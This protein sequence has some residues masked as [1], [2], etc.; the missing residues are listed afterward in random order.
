MKLTVRV[1]YLHY[2]LNRFF[3]GEQ[4][5]SGFVLGCNPIDMLLQSTLECLYD[6]TCF[7]LIN[8]GNLSSIYP[9]NASVPSRYR[10]NSTAE[11]LGM[12]TFLEEVIQLV[13]FKILFTMSTSI[14][15]VFKDTEE[16]HS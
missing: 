7:Q 13:L 6:K 8:F 9:L 2:A 10:I 14:L 12:S 4:K 16:K 3:V 15:Y 11:E 5:V 1:E